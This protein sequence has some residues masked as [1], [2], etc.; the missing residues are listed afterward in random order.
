MKKWLELLR[1]TRFY[2]AVGLVNVASVFTL[3]TVNNPVSSSRAVTI[4]QAKSV[5]QKPDAVIGKP[6]R[7]VIPSLNLQLQIDE[8]F[9]NPADASWTLSGFNAHF[10]MPSMLAN[11]QTGNTLLYGHNNKDVFGPLKQLA[12]GAIVEVLTDNNHLF[13]YKL[14]STTTIP[15]EDVSIF[16]Y[17]GPPILTLQ[18]CSGNWNE[19]RTMSTFTLDRVVKFNPN[20]EIERQNRE[21]FMTDLDNLSSPAYPQ[22]PLLKN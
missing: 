8:G 18:T 11:D 19:L 3:M 4:P 7:L 20:A 2:V 9:Y 21:K 5:V 22:A 17:E 15:P 13:Y 14:Q 12:P 6:V 16:A 1:K 10:A